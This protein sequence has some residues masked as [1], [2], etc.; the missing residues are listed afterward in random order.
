[1]NTII[2][3]LI[4]K[5][6]NDADLGRYLRKMFNENKEDFK[7]LKEAQFQKA[8]NYG[9]NELELSANE[10]VKEKEILDKIK[11]KLAL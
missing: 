11:E 4:K 5:Y 9:K 8:V 6:P 7:K 1:M 3:K 2:E 10:R